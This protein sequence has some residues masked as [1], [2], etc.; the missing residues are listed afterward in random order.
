MYMHAC[1]LKILKLYL[2]KFFRSTSDSNQLKKSFTHMLLVSLLHI[3][4]LIYGDR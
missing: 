4:P 3:Q 2:I 1:I